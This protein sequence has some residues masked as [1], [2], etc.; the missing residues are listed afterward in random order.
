M[1]KNWVLIA[2]SEEIIFRG[3]MINMILNT[4]KKTYLTNAIALIISTFAF[5]TIH[6]YQGLGGMI[7]VG[8]GGLFFGFLYLYYKN[9]YINI[10]VHGFLNTLFLLKKYLLHDTFLN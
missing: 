4:L 8:I 2:P 6:S 3:Y 10:F 1:I 5:V 7:N 9:L